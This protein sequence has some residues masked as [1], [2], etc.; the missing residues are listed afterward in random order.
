MNDIDNY[1]EQFLEFL[2]SK[3]SVLEMNRDNNAYEIVKIPYGN[4]LDMLYASYCYGENFGIQEK[5]GYS[6]VYNRE[7]NEFYDL[8][9]SLRK[10][11]GY[12][13]EDRPYLTSTELFDE[14][15]K[16]IQDIVTDYVLENSDEFYE[17]VPDDYEPYS[18]KENDVYRDFFNG[19][20]EI[21][22]K[23]EY[24]IQDYKVLLDYLD[25]GEDFVYD[26]S[27]DNVMKNKENIGKS[28]VNIDIKNKYL[29]NII[30]NKGHRIHKIKD[31]ID[32]LKDEDCNMVHVFI[33]KD[34]LNYDFKY[35]REYLLN[36]YDYSYLYA[37]NIPS[38]ERSGFE[39]LYGRNADFNYGDITKIEFRNKI[40]YLDKDF[41][42]HQKLDNTDKGLEL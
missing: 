29:N 4:N 12:S 28:L 27:L 15:N 20:N 24:D 42:K 8:N 14:M 13:W 6:G 38:K 39:N 2:K 16:K 5:L 26:F 22:Y 40:L 41:D 32:S 21:K 17:A 35:N 7:T 30:N 11:L 18:I 9:Y 3:D 33:Y 23:S 10:L 37:W 36:N 25:K 1:K 19:K 34:G 31:I